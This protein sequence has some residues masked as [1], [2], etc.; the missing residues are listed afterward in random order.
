MCSSDLGVVP[1]IAEAARWY[2]RAA[3]QGKV[4]AQ[5]NLGRLYQLGSGVPKDLDKAIYWYEK[6]AAQG[7]ETATR[8]LRALLPQ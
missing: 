8:N 1:D 4:A 6:A 5:N 3:S 7:S 2:E